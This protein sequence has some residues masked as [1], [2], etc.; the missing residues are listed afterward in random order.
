MGMA[1]WRWS[2]REV[3]VASALAPTAL[4]FRVRPAVADTVLRQLAEEAAIWG[5]PLVF[6]GLYLDAAVTN[7]VAFNRFHMASRIADARSKAVGPNIDTLNGRAWLD[8]DQGPQVI[9]VPDTADRYYTV[10]LQDMY[11]NS[12]AYIGRRTTGTRAGAFAITPPGWSGNLPDGVTAI[13]APTT[14][15]LA[16]VRTLV[17]SSGDL[18][19]ARAIN[20]AMSIGPL[21][22]F[23]EG[24]VASP[25][26]DGA[27]DAFQPASRAKGLL[28]HQEVAQMGAGFFDRLGALLKR[29]PPSPAD[30]RMA[31][32]F[33]SLGLDGPRDPAVTDQL[34]AEA[35]EAGIS[36]AVRSVEAWPENGWLRRRNVTGTPTDP[37]IRAAD[38]IYGPGTQVAEES[39]FWNLR[40]SPDGEPLNGTGQYRMKFGPGQLPPVDAFWSLTLYDGNYFLFGNRLD[41][42]GISDRTDGLRFEA[43][44][45]LEIRVQAS[46]P[47]A[48]TNW[49]PAPE[50][51]FQLVFRT[52][53][54]REEVLRGTYKLPPLELVG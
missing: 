54:P 27:L 3:V 40:Q 31:A 17:T 37:L 33:A 7:G 32:R 34:L 24:Q 50:G 18:P 35:V 28:P 47:D 53:Q 41:R 15:V 11:M 19:N 52:Y 22:G 48:P 25:V 29:F 43:D 20:G 23:P 2:R 10:Q 38:N 49:L 45:S 21:S 46:E 4:A 9:A 42:Y 14:K 44:G 12:F 13:H 16:F 39:V 51:P 36:R 26:A 5:F 30:A 1:D 8:L 6:F